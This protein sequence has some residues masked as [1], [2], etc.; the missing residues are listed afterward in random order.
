LVSVSRSAETKYH[1]LDG[2]KQQ[3]FIVSFVEA[4]SQRSKCQQGHAQFETYS[5][6]IPCFFLALGGLLV[7]N[8]IPW[9]A[10]ASL[11]S[12]LSDSP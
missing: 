11:L 2:L 4:K 3:K 7:I 12:L 5:G 8:I 9:L 6:I 10:A 1:K